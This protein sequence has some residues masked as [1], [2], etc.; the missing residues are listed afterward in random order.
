MNTQETSPRLAAFGLGCWAF[1]G[2]FWLD[3][4]P[5]D[6]IRTIHAALRADI[7]HFDTAQ[8]YGNGKSEQIVGQQLRRFK[9][10]PRESVTIATKIQLP[11]EPSQ[12]DDLV[13]I[14]LRRLCTDYLDILYIHWPDSSKFL[15]PY[16]KT[17]GGLVSRGTV[18]ALGVSN[19][20]VDLVQ[21]A[22]ATVPIEYC[23]LPVSLLWRHSLDRLE[24]LCAQ[25]AIRMVAYS[26]QGMGLLSGCHPT[27][28]DFK[29]GDWRRNLFCFQ[30]HYLKAYQHLIAVIHT[31]ARQLDTSASNIALSWALQQPVEVV[32]TGARNRLQLEANLASRQI[33]LPPETLQK[34]ETAS[35][36]LDQRLPPEADNPF[37]HH[38]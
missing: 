33:R 24:A 26:P 3:Q 12:V 36:E 4:D 38:W 34:L 13:G 31:Q 16:L 25:H 22:L 28:N 10:I 9:D 15:A 21:E 5:K 35:R 19:F 30:D 27:V 20:P 14:S 6:S 18:R 29:P 7:R 1:G 23:Q 11:P 2:G 37:F 17:L 8:S 32:L